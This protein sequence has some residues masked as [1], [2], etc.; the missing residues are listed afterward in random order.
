MGKIEESEHSPLKVTLGA[1]VLLQLLELVER[2]LALVGIAEALAEL[3][4][5]LVPGPL[6]RLGV[7]E[8]PLHGGTAKVRRR[9]RDL[10]SADSH[11]TAARSPSGGE[12]R[13]TNVDLPWHGRWRRHQ[14]EP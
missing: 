10:L 3:L 8:D 7:G 12:V 6:C 13:M 14:A 1:T 5:E 4:D 9:V 11:R 2:R